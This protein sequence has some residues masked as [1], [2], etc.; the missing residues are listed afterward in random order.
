MESSGVYW[1]PIWNLLEGYE[2]ELLLVNARHMKAVPG[3]KT[4]VKDAEWIADLLP[5]LKPHPRRKWDWQVVM[6]TIFYVLRAG[7]A[8]RM[9]PSDHVPW[10]TAYHRVCISI[11]CNRIYANDS[12]TAMI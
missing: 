8:W 12:E 7:C 10:Q 9:M 4:D 11:G 2:L 5:E 6:N 1:K 3:R